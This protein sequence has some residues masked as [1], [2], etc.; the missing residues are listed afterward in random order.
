MF[1]YLVLVLLVFLVYGLV[2]MLLEKPRKHPGFKSSD[3]KNSITWWGVINH[4]DPRYHNPHDWPS[5]SYNA[6]LGQPKREEDS[7]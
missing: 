7:N 5:T 6:N 1:K 3:S 2:Q 4:D